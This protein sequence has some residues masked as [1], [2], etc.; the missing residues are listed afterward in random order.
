MMVERLLP[1]IKTTVRKHGIIAF[2]ICAN[3]AY[4]S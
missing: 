1:G 4:A 3:S 2:L